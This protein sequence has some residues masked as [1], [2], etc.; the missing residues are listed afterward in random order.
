MARNIILA[1][2]SEIRRQLLRNA[3]VRFESDSPRLDE[4][5][6]KSA[7]LDEGAS[8]RDIADSLAEAKAMKLSRKR[9]EALVIG[10]D[11][12]LDFEGAILSKQGS[13]EEARDQL[14]RMRG[15][16]HALLSA[17]VLCHQGRPVWR[18]VGQVRLHMCD[19]SDGYLDGYLQRNWDSIR[20]AVGGYKLEEEGV[21]LFSRIEGDYF[22]VLG[23][24]LVELLSYLSASGDLDT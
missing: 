5:A 3:A 12:V 10:C 6:I 2:A 21:R 24:P 23:L 15:K 8:P 19:V 9:P 1:S 22:T 20:H 14:S 7:L 18:H 11:Q 13:P 4:E 17:V 16:R